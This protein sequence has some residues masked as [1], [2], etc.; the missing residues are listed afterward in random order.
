MTDLATLMRDSARAG[1]QTQLDA[2]VT[3]G[4]TEAARKIAAD[5]AKLEVSTAPKA[6]PYGDV[7]IRSFLDKQP[8]FGTD[9]KKSG[10]ALQLGKDMDPK[11]FPNAEAFAAA[12]VKAVD[13]EFKPAVT[14]KPDTGEGDDEDAETDEER[15][16]REAAEAAEKEKPTRRRTDGPGEADAAAR[17]ARRPSGPWTKLTDA[18]KDVQ[19]EI[20]RTADK[21]VPANSP[22]ER[23]EGY[24]AMALESHYAAHQR[25]AKAGKR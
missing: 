25:T 11:K 13:D 10:R 2:A 18:P 12:L 24:I 5:I 16:E 20:K 21:Y 9:P 22:K 14:P 23:R 7:E 17:S 8:W 4:N 19:A 15:A 1:L 6:P 3:E